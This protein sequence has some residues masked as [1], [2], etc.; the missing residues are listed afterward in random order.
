MTW[1]FWTVMACM[2]CAGCAT[3]TASIR[4]LQPAEANN[5]P[6]TL[7]V[8]DVLGRRDQAAVAQAAVVQQLRESGF[9]MVV[10]EAELQRAAA[11][12]LRH[13]DGNLNMPVALAAARQLG[14]DALLVSTLE[15]REAS[16]APY[17]TVTFR[18][19]DPNIAAKL[20]FQLIDTRNANVLEQ[21]IASSDSYKGELEP[22]STS[23]NGEGRILTGLTRQAASRLAHQL[24]PH[25][26]EVEV[27]LAGKALGRGV[28]EI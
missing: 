6:H 4:Q 7:G 1:K 5:L 21:N 18:V 11:A 27:R 19:G 20:A 17:G 23:S 28:E 16:G 12:S 24:A 25:T 8:L 2:I 3:Q 22:F 26:S 10:E 15:I 13:Q 9:Y 14:V